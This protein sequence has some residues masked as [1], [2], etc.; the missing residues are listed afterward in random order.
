MGVIQRDV[1]NIHKSIEY[2]YFAFILRSAKF[3]RM[4]KFIN[5][6]GYYIISNH[7]D[8]SVL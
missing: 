5:T 1:C 2:E 6:L 4:K 3:D 8:T 7:I